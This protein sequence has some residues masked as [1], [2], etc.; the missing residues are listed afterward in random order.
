MFNAT[1]KKPSP[2]WIHTLL[3]PLI[4]VDVTSSSLCYYLGDYI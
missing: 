3:T 4:K 2:D 1:K